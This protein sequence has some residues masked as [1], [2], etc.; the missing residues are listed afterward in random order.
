MERPEMITYLEA[1]FFFFFLTH[2]E[3][4][5]LISFGKPGFH[6]QIV[7]NTQFGFFSFKTSCVLPIF[8]FS[9]F[10][11]PGLAPLFEEK[12]KWAKMRWP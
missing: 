10:F 7:H 2:A 1:P 11:I 4:F 6:I 9:V 5:L 3:F 8:I 12:K